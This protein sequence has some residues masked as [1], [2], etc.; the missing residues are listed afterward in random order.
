M[1]QAR[2]AH[3]QTVCT[4]ANVARFHFLDE[5]GLRLDYCRR[6]ARAKGE[7]RVGRVVPLT[8]GRSLTLIGERSVRGLGAVQLLEGSLNYVNF[9]WYVT[10]CLAPTL[11]RSDVLVRDNISV[12]KLPGVVGWLAERG[13]EVLFLPPYSPDFSPVEQAR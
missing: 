11:R 2:A 13:V 5:T 8:R 1:R 3:V 9:A 10:E 4:R 12:H 7:R 6:Y